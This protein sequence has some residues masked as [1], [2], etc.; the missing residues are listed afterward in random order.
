MLFADIITSR[1]AGRAA[2]Q[3]WLHLNLR[4]HLVC[5]PGAL[6]VCRQRSTEYPVWFR[7]PARSVSPGGQ[8]VRSQGRL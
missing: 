1:F 4:E 2:S 6:V 3:D 8:G 5:Q 7:V